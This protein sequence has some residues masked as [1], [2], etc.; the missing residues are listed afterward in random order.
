MGDAASEAIA[1]RRDFTFG[2]LAVAFRVGQVEIRGPRSGP[3]ASELAG[4]V[5]ALRE[6]V[7]SDDCARYR[8]LS[9]A[10]TMPG[11]WRVFLPEMLTEAAIDAIYPQ[12]LLHQ[13]QAA[14]GTLRVTPFEEVVARQQ[15]RYRIAGELDTE[16]RER[17]REAL[18]GR[19]VRTPVWAGEAASKEAIPCPE[20]CSVM[21]ALCREAALWQREAPQASSP[22][23]QAP[24]ADFSAPGNEVR[25]AYLARTPAG[26]THG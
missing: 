23:P 14:E 20:P 25:E 19:C 1:A 4:R 16:G 7:R 15:G 2:E 26:A 3:D 6:H 17:A 18:C 22:D 24:F 21:V 5:E 8:P 13:R 9:G 10:R 11:N 12:A